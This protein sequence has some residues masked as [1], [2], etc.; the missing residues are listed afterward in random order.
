MYAASF[1]PPYV[2][3]TNTIARPNMPTQESS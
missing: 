1:Q 3:S 2:N